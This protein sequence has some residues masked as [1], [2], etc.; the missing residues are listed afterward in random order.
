[1]NVIE[2]EQLAAQ[3]V[4]VMDAHF[5]RPDAEQKKRLLNLASQQIDAALFLQNGQQ[6][7]HDGEGRCIA[8]G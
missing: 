2:K 4:A 8:P 1:M 3:M 7:V 5:S 6:V